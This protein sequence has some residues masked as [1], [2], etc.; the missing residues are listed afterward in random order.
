MQFAA[1]VTNTSYTHSGLQNGTRYYY[2]IKANNSAGSSDFSSTRAGITI[3]PAPSSVTATGISGF[4]AN[5]SWSSVPGATS[6]E[7]YYDLGNITNPFGGRQ[8]AG[9]FTGTSCTINVGSNLY[10][11]VYVRAKN[12]IATSELRAAPRTQAGSY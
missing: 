9:E 12:S 10:L 3:L 7:V 4:R 2:Y 1:N 8:Y 6:Y 11:F 5:V